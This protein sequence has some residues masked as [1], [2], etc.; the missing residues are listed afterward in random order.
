MIGKL[1][2]HTPNETFAATLYCRHPGGRQPNDMR[3]VDIQAVKNQTT[4][5]LLTSKLSKTKRHA[6]RRHYE[7]YIVDR[8]LYNI[9][10]F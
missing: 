4:W 1:V 2:Q 3:I 10:P 5:A 6:H 9:G 8:H 7:N